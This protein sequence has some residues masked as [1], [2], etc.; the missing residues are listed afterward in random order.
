[1]LRLL[2]IARKR[3]IMVSSNGAKPQFRGKSQKDHTT[4]KEKSQA[5]GLK[6]KKIIIYAGLNDKV[7]KK[8]EISTLD[9]YKVA[10]N[11]FT[12]R[13]GGAT[14]SE[15]VGVYT[16]Q[17]GEIVTEKTLRCEI[18]SDDLEAVHRAALELKN[19]LNQ[20]SIMIETVR[21]DSHYI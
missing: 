10:I 13:V 21:T 19:A 2:T 20:E 14:I 15:A 5:E 17:D 18:C 7:T 3:S 8:Q 1:M 11:I 16:H 9:A 4:K 6:M 12:A